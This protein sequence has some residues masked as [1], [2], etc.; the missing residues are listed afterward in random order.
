MVALA[1][2]IAAMEG[3]FP[4]SWAESWDAVGLVCGDPAEPVTRVHLA[5]DCVP[6]TV[7]EAHAAGAQLLLTHHPLLLG[8]V[9]T[10][11]AH[12]TKGAMVHR[13]VSQGTAL[14]V[15]HTNA[16]VAS[17]GVSDAL[18]ERIGL[19]DVRPLIEDVSERLYKIVVFVPVYGADAMIDA[20]AG[21]GAGGLGAY[22][23]CA[24]TTTGVGTFRPG[25][26]AAPAIGEPGR[27]EQ[28]AE[29]RVEMVLAPS[30]LA[31]V[32]AAMRAA[33]PYEE[34]AF[35]VLA[36]VP[37]PTGRGTGRIGE[38]AAPTTLARFADDVAR[39]LPAT[40][41]GVRIAGKPDRAVSRVAVCG[42]SGAAYIEQARSAGADVF[43]TADLKHHT[44]VEAVTEHGSDAM[45]L[46]DA[47]HWATEAPWLDAAAAAL[48]DRFGTTVETTVSHLVTDPWTLHRPSSAHQ[49]E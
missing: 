43:L 42:G 35:D 23:R 45:A 28:V 7:E 30:A 17:P 33:H 41:W 16:D 4:P 29:A 11:G 44:T 22:D 36:H 49:P 14:Y 18:A 31:A 12:T 10:V 13:L 47:A 20:L 26:R 8:G 3:W 37:L 15:A 19:S 27:I 25:A 46:I 24:W 39:L 21:A 32:V 34:P 1:E 2:V 5:V 6:E 38:L 48:R 40:A 9:T